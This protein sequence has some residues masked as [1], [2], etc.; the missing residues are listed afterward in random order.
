MTKTQ[1]S[2]VRTRALL[3]FALAY[4]VFVLLLSAQH[5]ALVFYLSFPLAVLWAALFDWNYWAGVRAWGVMFLTW[6]IVL[7]TAVHFGLLHFSA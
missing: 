1:K 7:G 5:G 4:A 6:G 3:G 2:P